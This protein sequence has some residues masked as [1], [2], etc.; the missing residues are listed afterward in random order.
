[1]SENVILRAK[2]LLSR[3]SPLN[4]DCGRLCGK[5]CCGGEDV[6]MELLPGEETLSPMLDFGEEKNGI[7]VC[8]GE[9]ERKCRPYACMMF[10]LFPLAEET[11]NGLRITA[12]NDLRAGRL[13]PI[14]NS[15]LLPSFYAAVRRSA[16]ILCENDALKT[17][18]LEKTEEYREIARL[19]DLLTRAVRP[20]L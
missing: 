9:C 2:E 16:R 4:T 6:G 14:A 11:E 10:P 3:A 7:F 15:R 13:C 1:M 19:N 18:L 20:D 17:Y 8:R 12:V 5:R